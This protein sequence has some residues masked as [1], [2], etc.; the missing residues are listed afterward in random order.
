MKAV[1]YDEYT[2]NNDFKKILKLKDIDHPKP[3]SDEVIIKINTA[4][5]NY[6]DIWGMGGNPVPVPHI[7]GSE[8]SGE[9]TELGD[10]VTHLKVGDRVAVHC[11]ISCRICVEC[12]EGREYNFEL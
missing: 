10:T 7:S 12:I 11:N 8:A 3:K 4:A 6:N 1:V 9:V 5:L 2:P